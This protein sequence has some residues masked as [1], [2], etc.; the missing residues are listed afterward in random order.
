M[1]FQF[2]EFDLHDAREVVEIHAEFFHMG[3]KAQ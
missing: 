3:M 2:T 1:Q